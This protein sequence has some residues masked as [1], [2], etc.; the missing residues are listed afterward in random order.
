MTKKK[1]GFISRLIG[2]FDKRLEEKSKAKKC[3][4]CEDS[5]NKKC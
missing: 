3:C 2:K 4:C 5:K 1:K